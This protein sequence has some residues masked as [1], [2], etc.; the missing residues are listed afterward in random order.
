MHPI[1]DDPDNITIDSNFDGTT[2][3]TLTYEYDGLVSDISCNFSVGGS[4]F[5]E[6]NNPFYI[7]HDDINKSLTINYD[8]TLNGGMISQR[9]IGGD[10][11][12]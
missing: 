7:T 10:S 11:N 5:D 2:I 12:L 6:A 8:P 3:N 4:Y 9:F 1:L